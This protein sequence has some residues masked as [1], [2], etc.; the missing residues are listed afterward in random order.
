MDQIIINEY[1]ELVNLSKDSNIYAEY[2]KGAE[3]FKALKEKQERLKNM[4]GND[5]PA[6]S[7][8]PNNGATAN[9]ELPIGSS[10]NKAEKGKTG[11]K[12]PARQRNAHTKPEVDIKSNKECKPFQGRVL[13]VKIF[14]VNFFVL[15]F[16][17][18]FKIPNFIVRP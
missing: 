9:T 1:F 18:F 4:T 7:S 2:K 6:T 16:C 5:T 12:P 17:L 8:K 10:N 3:I 11:L 14:P 13:F 15:T